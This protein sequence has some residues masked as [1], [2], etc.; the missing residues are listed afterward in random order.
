MNYI[1]IADL[2]KQAKKERKNNNSIKNH[3]ESLNFVAKQN[4]YE[5]WSD[6]ID[7]SVLIKN[8]SLTDIQQIN[9][10]KEFV[11]ESLTLINEFNLIF[12]TN[13]HEILAIFMNKHFLYKSNNDTDEIDFWKE[14]AKKW[15][16]QVCFIFTNSDL[17]RNIKGL[18]HCFIFNNLLEI[19][20]EKNLHQHENIKCLFELVLY[21]PQNNQLTDPSYN[22]L[23]Q[24]GYCSMQFTA[25]VGFIADS[26]FK[27]LNNEFSISRSK[28][29]EIILNQPSLFSYDAFGSTCPILDQQKIFARYKNSFKNDAEFKHTLKKH[30]DLI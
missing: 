27:L 12:K 13:N 5:N 24:S 16:E 7:S 4:N 3:A 23:E 9:L 14:R 1:T 15:M 29:K 8:N 21:E 10:L 26:L 18:R 25:H 17:P 19:I 30:L 11:N 22:V 28:I 20:E 6:L 2:K